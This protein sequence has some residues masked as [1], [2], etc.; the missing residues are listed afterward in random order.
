MKITID[1]KIR[2]TELIAKAAESIEVEGLAMALQRMYWCGYA[3]A[4]QE[5]MVQLN[6]TMMPK[7]YAGDPA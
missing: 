4:T 1:H 7:A 6:E 5:V 2:I 3:D